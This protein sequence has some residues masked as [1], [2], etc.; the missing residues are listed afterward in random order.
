MN[1]REIAGKLYTSEKTDRTIEAY[2]VNLTFIQKLSW[3]LKNSE[4]L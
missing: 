1:I 4:K 2:T 3:Q